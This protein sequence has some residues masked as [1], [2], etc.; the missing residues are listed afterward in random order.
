[1]VP[2]TG[3]YA[4][5]LIFLTVALFVFVPAVSHASGPG[6]KS[7]QEYLT[8]LPFTMPAMAEPVFPDRTLRIDQFGAIGDGLTLN[9]AAFAGAIDSCSK[10]GGGTVIV[11]PGTWLTG[12]IR[13]RDNINL[14]LERGA[15]VQFSGRLKDFPLTAGYDGKSKKFQITPPVL[16]YRVKNIAITGEGVFDGAGEAWRPVKKE[17]Q[18]AKEWKELIASGGAVSADG[19]IWWPSQQ[20]LE[21]EEYLKGLDR[22]R[23][24]TEAEYA[25]AAEFLRPNMVHLVQCEGILIDGP[26]FS[27]SP[28][29]HVYPVQ[30]EQIIVR[31]I[32]IVTP[33]SAQNG[34]GLD[35]NACRNVVVYNVT[36]DAGDDAICIKPGRIADRQKPGPACENIVIADC[37]VYH[38][39]GGFVIGSE[40]FGGAR[41]ISVKNCTFIGTDVG[42]RFKSARGKGGE[43]TNIFIDGI[44]MRGIANEAI[45]FDMNYGEGDPESQAAQ[46]GDGK[47]KEQ[48]DGQTPRFHDFTISNVICTGA[49]RAILINGLREATVRSI[50]MS[51]L[52][53]KTDR[54]MLCIDAD[55]I[56]LAGSTISVANGPAISL[57][58]S[59]DIVITGI[60]L[61]EVP[62]PFLRV[63]GEHVSGVIVEDVDLSGVG[64]PF[65]FEQGALPASVSYKE[66]KK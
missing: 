30:S 61:P 11:P 58:E 12:P 64:N 49:G 2:G 9:T 46:G 35:F 38:G 59:R 45:L 31:N 34:D 36:V 20:A 16:A 18:T 40:S 33:W 17:K 44:R 37:I 63:S 25:K 10:V 1:M 50:R 60:R 15:L 41:N 21:A 48:P 19:K 42:L 28:R 26:T 14:R 52:V 56:S 6:T 29:F 39:H 62:D 57:D 22:S 51:G 4:F 24:G 13:L 47:T 66:G 3:R 43:I 27:N 54:G 23:K 65:V 5:I 7:L 55:S 53:M 32:K 8:G